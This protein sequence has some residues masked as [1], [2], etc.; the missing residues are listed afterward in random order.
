MSARNTPAQIQ[1]GL[2]F[3]QADQQISAGQTTN[4]A[5]PFWN[6]W[7]DF[8]RKD[9]ERERLD[10]ALEDFV[11]GSEACAEEPYQQIARVLVATIAALDAQKAYYTKWLNFARDNS[12]KFREL[13]QN[14]EGLRQ[15][16]QANLEK[17][18]SEIGEQMQRI[19]ILEQEMRQAGAQTSAA[20]DAARKLLAS[21]QARR[22]SLRQ[23]LADW[24][25]AD[26][27]GKLS[28]EQGDR[29]RDDVR[30]SVSVVDGM[31]ER[32]HAYYTAMDSRIRLKCWRNLR[33]Q[34]PKL[35]L[36]RKPGKEK[37]K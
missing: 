26:M 19:Q 12:A 36:P 25:K 24:Q 27:D 34:E 2:T 29:I 22:E 32:W 23:A 18:E 17:V 3:Q 35:I 13:L 7:L 37:S 5:D 1:K 21:Q 8:Q 14:R 31:K 30:A 6:E 20:L 15:T 16:T 11:E 4:S 10:D 9:T 28:I 33:P